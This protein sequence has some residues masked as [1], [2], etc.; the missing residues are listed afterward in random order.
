MEDIIRS[1][2]TKLQEFLKEQGRKWEKPNRL[3]RSHRLLISDYNYLEVQETNSS[4]VPTLVALGHEFQSRESKMTMDGY[5]Y[6]VSWLSHV[7][8]FIPR[9]EFTGDFIRKEITIRTVRIQA[10][11]L[12]A[13]FYSR[14][15]ASNYHVILDGKEAVEAEFALS[16]I[17]KLKTNKTVSLP[18]YRAI[19]KEIASY[20]SEYEYSS[21][22]NTKVELQMYEPLFDCREYYEHKDHFSTKIAQET[23]TENKEKLITRLKELENASASR[24]RPFRRTFYG[25]K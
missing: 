2:K 13:E 10:V 8:G 18:T 3:F 25:M 7:L 21:L 20:L 11:E 6:K 16:I 14:S 19:E 22:P 5:F 4:D 24:T 23:D 15:I 17:R 1:N 9:Y 12:L